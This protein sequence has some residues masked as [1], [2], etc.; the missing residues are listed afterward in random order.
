MGSLDRSRKQVEK[1]NDHFFRIGQI[2]IDMKK[3]NNC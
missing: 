2:N 3:H 1:C